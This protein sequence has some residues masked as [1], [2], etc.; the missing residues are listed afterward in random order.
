FERAC[1]QTVHVTDVFSEKLAA[2]RDYTETPWARIRYRVAGEL[3]RRQ[4]ERL[5]QHIRV[6]DVGGGDGMDALPLALAGHEVTIIDPSTEWLDE[7][8]RRASAAGTAFTTICGSLDDLPDG[9]WDLVVCHFVLRYRSGDADDIAALARRVR[10]GGRLSI[11]DVN[12]DGRVLR[13][14]LTNGPAAALTELQAERAAVRL[15][16]TDV[17]KVSVDVVAHE[18]AAVGLSP[19]GIYGI[20]IANE[21]LLDDTA[22]HDP[23]F[24]EEL[25]TLEL[26]L[27]GREPFNRAGFAWQLIMQR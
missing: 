8:T 15:F 4:T 13:E 19:L 7:A 26:E 24:F 9:D 22:K 14:L 21:L 25:L 23:V 12:P 2:W 6:L 18:A 3:L 1:W 11:M 10:P 16:Q 17:R 27:S 5:G 20:R